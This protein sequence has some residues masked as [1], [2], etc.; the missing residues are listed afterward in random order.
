M[1]RKWTKAM[2]LALTA[3]MAVPSSLG[4]VHLTVKAD[5]VPVN[6]PI[7]E[8]TPTSTLPAVSTN[9]PEADT[10]ITSGYDSLGR[11]ESTSFYSAK[12]GN[13]AVIGAG[14]TRTL[15][16]GVFKRNT[17]TNRYELP[18]EEESTKVSYKWQVKPYS[19]S[20]TNTESNWVEL[21][22]TAVLNYTANASHFSS[23]MNQTVIRCIVTITEEG[24][25]STRDMDFYL[26][27]KAP[28]RFKDGLVDP[29][30]SQDIMMG[31]SATFHADAMPNPGYTVEYQWSKNSN[32]T[33]D[34]IPGATA[35][36]YTTTVYDEETDY[37]A[38]YSCTITAKNTAGTV[39]Y[40]E[41]L[42]YSVENDRGFRLYHTSQN[43][44]KCMGE[45]VEL[46]V[47]G[48]QYDATK[49]QIKYDW[50][51]AKSAD[52]TVY[53]VRENGTAL[54]SATDTY[55]V[56]ALTKNKDTGD[57][58]FTKYVCTVY[59]F[60]IGA[61]IN[62][63][64]KSVAS[65]YKTFNIEEASNLYVYGTKK[66]QKVQLGG[67]V[68]LTVGASN[69]NVQAYPITYKW[70][71]YNTATSTYDEQVSQVANTL[72]LAN[73]TETML[74]KYRVDVTDG[75]ESESV[76][77]TV[78]EDR[79][80]K[81]T[82]PEYNVAYKKVGE[83]ANLKVDA[84]SAQKYPVTYQWY[85]EGSKIE[86]ATLPT[87]DASIA[88][89]TNYGT[90]TCEVTNTID[91]ETITFEVY[92]NNGFYVE[93]VTETNV[94]KKVGASQT[95]KV[96]AGSDE[97]GTTY[98]Y[99][100]SF[101]HDVDYYYSTDYNYGD[102]LPGK[103]T[104]TLDLSNLTLSDFGTYTC[105][106][107]NQTTGETK[108]IS[109]RLN[110]LTQFDL[111]Y[112]SESVLRRNEGEAATLAVNPVNPQGLPVEY[113][114]SVTDKDDKT[115]KIGGANTNS[116]AIAAMT[117]GQY[118]TYTC[119][120]I[121]N[122][123]I[124]LA[125]KTFYIRE[126]KEN[127][128]EAEA[129]TDI[130]FKETVGTPINMGVSATTKEGRTLSYQW[131]KGDAYDEDAALVG[132]TAATY[133]IPSLRHA[134]AGT[135]SCKIT[136][137]EGEV[138]RITFYVNIDTGLVVG[139]EGQGAEDIKSVAVTYNKSTTL[140]ATSFEDPNY[141][142]TYQWYYSKEGM[143][144][145]DR[146]M[147]VDVVASNYTVPAVT[148][149]TIGYYT[150]RVSN[151]RESYNV[152]YYVFG[153]TN[154][155]LKAKETNV[156]AAI[157]AE[158]TLSVTATCKKGFTPSYQWYFEQEVEKTEGNAMEYVAIPGATEATYKI[159]AMAKA[160]YGNYKVVV[161]TDGEQK[162]VEYT[163]TK[164][165]DF[166]IGVTASTQ[167]TFVGSE[168]TF[169]SAVTAAQKDAVVEYNWYVEDT[170]TGDF[171]KVHNKKGKVATG[172]SV[173]TVVPKIY[174]ENVKG[175]K[176]QNVTYKVVA[177]TV[178]NN[179]TYTAADTFTVMV[180]DPTYK[181]KLPKSAH[182][183]KAGEVTTYA[184][185]AK[186][187]VGVMKVTFDKKFNI[188]KDGDYMY[189][190]DGN[191]KA[192]KYYGTELQNKTISVDGNKFVIVLV[193]NNP[194]AK[195]YGFAVTKIKTSKALSLK[196]TKVKLGKKEKY[197]IGFT[198][199]V[200]KAT[201]KSKNKKIASVNKKGVVVAK[202]AGKTVIVVKANS[203][204]FKLNVVVQKA[205]K[206]L[207]VATK[208][209]TVKRGKKGVVKYTTVGASQ[210]INVT[211]AKQLKKAKITVKKTAEGKIA[212]K[213]A[214]KAKKKTYTVKI[215]TFNKKK[216]TF[217]VKVK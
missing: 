214:K 48:V 139:G 79:G 52:D 82:T 152:C 26:S 188:N 49:Y 216:A 76:Y 63:N 131:Y 210:A 127:L 205:A 140:D 168:I 8:G 88:N 90:Y 215:S 162:A 20:M 91:K 124:S 45:A 181:K 135:Y 42:R 126:P 59:L 72:Q 173:T 150:C 39:V 85:F 70:Y 27:M 68:N 115:Q 73:V 186:A 187:S 54:N 125:S 213:V 114:W 172:A 153:D 55:A 18:S 130:T 209:I 6:S 176:W 16:V 105:K 23:D 71:K 170:K 148:K 21:G 87:Y 30:K 204:T 189:I 145:K 191:G 143:S 102:T 5:E 28:Y 199:K 111:E 69:K 161:S 217:K 160:N 37:L 119:R 158:A 137:S 61:D 156:I 182:N 80:W 194:D 178:V 164:P 74:G 122:G 58:D 67:T 165:E 196:D 24:K 14:E 147:M 51:K 174:S 185:K 32:G 103:S 207:K 200:K 2:A 132:A 177:K 65:V 208:K 180:V 13:T 94:S 17:A 151:A 1:K 25:T 190:I 92:N 212:V 112:A 96:R 193:S 136:D 44:E 36:S 203:Q 184:Y 144:T 53:E 46:K 50:K 35:P 107:V 86:G 41:I 108:Y 133:T 110:Y 142:T 163:I 60:P 192:K 121:Y 83:V 128:L 33:D 57:T 64:T 116:Y 123:T 195:N 66:E 211:N 77:F 4:S 22:T 99:Q 167:A 154:L 34:I 47:E 104:D 75:L 97:V 171:V 81:V 113:I 169:K 62:D 134:D 129:T 38:S 40:T 106:V 202:K 3:T 93:A 117:E 118:G 146:D 98:S 95:F 9:M 197:K 206:K 155:R 101:R 19:N 11:I 12:K 109:F 43:Y 15:E 84:V 198:T 89:E 120:A 175:D 157:G 7:V 31:Q 56:Q 78:T 166:A 141:P 29:S 179:K 100:W 10:S 201:Y 183:Y 149:D 159:P 138:K